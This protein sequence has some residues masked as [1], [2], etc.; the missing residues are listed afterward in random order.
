M[1]TICLELAHVH[2]LAGKRITPDTEDMELVTDLLTV[3]F[4][5]GMLTANTFFQF[6]RGRRE[7][8]E[9]GA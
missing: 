3:Y 4:G 5:A 2:L 7:T 6:S 9:A 8:G 1:A